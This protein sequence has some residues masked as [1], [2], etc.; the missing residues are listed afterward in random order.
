MVNPA[1]VVAEVL[2]MS[3]G[4]PTAT[5]E[6]VD[7]CPECTETV[8]WERNDYDFRDNDDHRYSWRAYCE[9]CRLDLELIPEP[10]PP[11]AAAAEGERP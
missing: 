4:S 2:S 10:N 11:V 8:T 1:E 6:Q 9:E 7:N 3:A 5:A